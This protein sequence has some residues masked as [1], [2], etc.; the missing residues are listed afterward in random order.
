MT[1]SSFLTHF[2][3]SWWERCQ[4]N[5]MARQS[6]VPL[7]QNSGRGHRIVAF[8]IATR[9]A[10]TRNSV[11]TAVQFGAVSQQYVAAELRHPSRPISNSHPAAGVE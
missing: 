11:S 2:D 9:A 4:D 1:R 3:L 7:T 6:S 8:G 5:L 10:R